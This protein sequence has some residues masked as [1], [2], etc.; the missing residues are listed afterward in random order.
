MAILPASPTA[1]G[2]GKKRKSAPPAAVVPTSGKRVLAIAPV[3]RVR[4]EMPDNTIRD[5]G[6]DFLARLRTRFT[7]ANEFVVVDPEPEFAIQSG[8]RSHKAAPDG[9]EWESSPVPAATVRIDV[10][11]MSFVTG[12]RGG[13]MF[14]GFDDRMR[15][16][17]NDGSGNKLNEF[18]I[19]TAETGQHQPSW[20]DGNFTPY[21]S[22]PFDS[23]S[24]LDLGDGFGLDILFAWLRV[25]YAR[26]RAELKLVVDIQAPLANRNERRAVHVSG[27]GYFYD[28]AGGYAA[29]DGAIRIARRDAMLKAFNRAFEQASEHIRKT[30]G[31]LPLTAR[32]DALSEDGRIFIATGRRAEI[33]AGTRYLSIEDPSLILLVRESFHAG[34]VASLEK[35]EL[36][37]LYPGMILREVSDKFPAPAPL[38]RMHLAAMDSE[39]TRQLDGIIVDLPAENLPVPEFGGSVKK[40]SRLRA[41]FKSLLET[42]FLPYR[43]WRYYQYD[44]SYKAR[45]DASG[46]SIASEAQTRSVREWA[47]AARTETWARKIGITDKPLEQGRSPVVAIIDSGIDYNHPALHDALWLNP[48][49]TRDLSGQLDRYGWDFISGDSRPNDDGYH[50]TRVASALLAI[51]PS[52]RIMPLKVFNPWGVTSSAAI[53]GAFEYAVSHGA[54][55]ILCAWSTR[56]NSEALERGITLA[57]SKNIPVVAAAGDLGRDLRIAPSYPAAYAALH[58]N[59]IIVTAVDSLDRPLKFSNGHPAHVHLAAPGAAIRVAEP[60]RMETRASSTGIAAAIAAGALARLI[61]GIPEGDAQDTHWRELLQQTAEP[62]AGLKAYSEGGLS[63]RVDR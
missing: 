52:A 59:L 14:Y 27:K 7:Q 5:F 32:I 23:L 6:D 63:L 13:R 57:G 34:S 11:A 49:P 42:V 35:G 15:N 60:R 25:K 36:S 56:R 58:P 17:F 29:W 48:A 20:F 16:S 39:S 24:G 4:I 46:D 8:F 53:L 31:P 2:A 62:V 12:A 22:K 19:N 44:R 10:D 41:F 21:G 45:S 30:V 38:S 61:S 33:A 54:D 1:H 47:E 50:G 28:V 43:I 37:R 18:P 26:Y 55:L 40:I 3:E 9:F 51:A